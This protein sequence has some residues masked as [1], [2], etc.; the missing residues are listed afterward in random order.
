MH[1]AE[2]A[3]TLRGVRATRGTFQLDMPELHIP[4]GKVVGLVGHNGCG[5][6]TLLRLLHGFDK[7]DAGEIEVLGHDP[8]RNPITVRRQV[9]WMSDDMPLFD[10]PIRFL[11]WYSSGLYPSWDVD[12]V[13][14]LIER[15]DIDLSKR[16]SQLSKGQGTRLRLVCAMAYRPELLI[17][18]EPAT[19]LDLAG[20]RA[21]LRTVMEIAQEDHRTI[22]IS[23][24]ALT[25]LHRIADHLIVM[26]RG[27]IIQ[28]GPM[29]ELVPDERSLEE[30]L[31]AWEGAP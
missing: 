5:K 8:I 11:L 27:A 31:V 16:P 15:F 2:P 24:H 20:R 9:G 25:D 4:R 6:T 28:Q 30:Q 14:T 18:D 10:L 22:V 21:L 7:A 26:R 12:L 3:V 13:Q 1:P 17:L 23:S 29:H 19:G